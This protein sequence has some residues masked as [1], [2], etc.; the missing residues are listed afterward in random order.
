MSAPFGDALRRASRARVDPPTSHT[1]ARVPRDAVSGRWS[2]DRRRIRGIGDAGSV[3]PVTEASESPFP[4][5]SPEVVRELLPLA[6]VPPLGLH[7][8]TC[9]AERRTDDASLA[10]HA[11][12]GLDD[13]EFDE[14]E[15]LYVVDLNKRKPTK[16]DK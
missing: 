2:F 13:L 11:R 9:R 14:G 8:A 5:P 16:K 4:R 10:A 3:R 7:A 15:G 6:L 12:V 1:P